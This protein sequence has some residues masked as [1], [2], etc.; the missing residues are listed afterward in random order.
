MIFS[1]FGVIVM[2][3]WCLFSIKV[4]L[5]IRTRQSVKTLSAILK[6]SVSNLHDKS[7]KLSD[8]FCQ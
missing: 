2:L 7:E 4:W 5:Q 3:V 6:S 8:S 1:V